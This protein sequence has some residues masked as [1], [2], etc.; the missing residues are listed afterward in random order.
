MTLSVPAEAS[1]SVR[2]FFHNLCDRLGFSL[3]SA[4]YA[5]AAFGNIRIIAKDRTLGFDYRLDRGD[6]SVFVVVGDTEYAIED[7]AHLIGTQLPCN[8][9]IRQQQTWILDHARELRQV[10]QLRGVEAVREVLEASRLERLHRM[11]PGSIGE[12]TG[13]GPVVGEDIDRA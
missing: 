5:P 13:T 2:N 6:E 1:D 12:E 7:A 8:I 10:L 9:D 3:V 4:T 11:F